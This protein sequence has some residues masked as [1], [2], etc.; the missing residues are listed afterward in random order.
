L[1]KSFR[2]ITTGKP[3]APLAGWRVVETR[4]VATSSGVS[5]IKKT[6]QTAAEGLQ[7]GRVEEGLPQHSKQ[8]KKI[9]RANKE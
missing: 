3:K 9:P 4:S 6:F 2:V 1:T 5:E 8:F 7:S